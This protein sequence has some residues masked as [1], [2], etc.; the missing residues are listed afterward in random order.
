DFTSEQWEAIIYCQLLK[1]LPVIYSGSSEKSG[2]HCFV[3]DGYDGNDHY[4]INWG[5]GGYLDGYFLLSALTPDTMSFSDDQDCIIN[6]FPSDKEDIYGTSDGTFLYMEIGNGNLALIGTADLNNKI[7]G[8][9]VLPD[10]TMINGT[11]YTVTSMLCS[12]SDILDFETLTGLDIRIP[13]TSIPR[14]SFWGATK[15][16]SIKF[17]STL[18]S[19]EYTAFYGCSELTGTLVIPNSVTSIG[20]WAFAYC[21][22]LTGTVTI[23]S[24]V[25]SIG[26]NAFLIYNNHNFKVSSTVPPTIDGRPFLAGYSCIGVPTGYGTDYRA[27]EGWAVYDKLYEF[28]DANIDKK[29]TIS[30]AVAVANNIIGVKNNSF[31]EFIAD[32]NFDE[33]ITVNDVARIVDAVLTYNPMEMAQSLTRAVSLTSGVL[34]ADDFRLDSDGKS[35]VGVRLDGCQ[36]A[37]ALQCDFI[38]GEDIAVDEIVPDAALAETHTLKMQPLDDGRIRVVIYSLD[39]K[40]ICTEN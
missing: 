10:E 39:N 12:F 2:G 31:N 32:I 23:P 33:Q 28:G 27:N 16:K 29:L 1:K 24:S 30:D 13:I 3:C 4:H 11:R 22:G 17:P 21:S 36:E 35:A 25:T 40:G 8:D 5:W 15:L 18:Q 20:G 37:V 34:T 9:V 38:L 6:F 7:G 14:Q 19:I 26:D